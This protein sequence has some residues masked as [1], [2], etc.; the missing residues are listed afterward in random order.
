MLTMV[1]GIVAS[2]KNLPAA[3]YLAA[4]KEVKVPDDQKMQ[5][6]LNAIGEG[7]DQVAFWATI[8]APAALGVVA[9]II[10]FLMIINNDHHARAN[11]MSWLKRAVGGAVVLVIGPWVMTWFWDLISASVG[12]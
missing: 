6:L 5:D 7:L 2:V 3:V 11:Q 9:S 8:L 12:K 1:K 4:E 10:G